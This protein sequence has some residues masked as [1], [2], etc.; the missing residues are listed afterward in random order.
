MFRSVLVANRGE[1]ALRIIK[2]LRALSIRSVAVYSQADADSPHLAAADATVCIGGARSS[3]SYL[4]MQA[5][6]QAAI[7]HDCQALHPGFGFL[8]ENARFATM[9]EQARITFIGPAPAAIRQ[10]GVKAAARETMRAAGLEPIP[11]SAGVVSDL[12]AAGRI[13]AD[14]GYPVLLKA[15]AGGGGRGMRVAENAAGLEEAFAAARMEAEK[16]FGNGDLYLEKFIRGGRHIEFQILADAYGHAIHL[17]ERECS[18]QRR[19]QKLIEESPS[20]TVSAETRRRVGAQVARAVARIGYRNAGTVEFLRDSD[21]SLYFMEMNTRLQVEHPVTEMVTG[22]DIVQQQIKLAANQPLAIAQEQV[23]MRG[24]SIE[25]RINAEDPEHDF[26]PTPGAITRFEP[27]RSG[28]DL[29]L[30]THVQEGY[31]VPPFYDSMIAKLIC[32][33]ADRAQAI[34]NT[35]AALEAFRIE[36]VRSTIPLHLRILRSPQFQSG[37]YDT[38]LLE[39]LFAEAQPPEG[40]NHG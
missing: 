7:Q 23:E 33:G 21:G 40:H 24:H 14:M 32:R 1:I 29:R 39:Q 17:G 36:G 8:A 15:S 22:V 18:V 28:P 30:D 26:R 38:T 9:C 3:D 25:V 37:T 2:A 10:M 4:N 5:I 27:P 35:I 16:A 20:P 19:H 34:A 31:V 13:A 6:I 12:D 11:G